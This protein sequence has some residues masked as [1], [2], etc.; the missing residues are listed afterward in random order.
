NHPM[1]DTQPPPKQT[2]RRQLLA[3]AARLPRLSGKASAAWLLICFILTGLLIPAVLRLP[4]WIEYEVVLAIW[5]VVWLAVLTRLLYTGQRVADDHRLQEPR[6]WF[7][8][9]KGRAESSPAAGAPSAV[10]PG[11]LASNKEGKQGEAVAKQPDTP[12][13]HRKGRDDHAAW[14]SGFFWGSTLGDGE[15]V[16]VGCLIVIGLVLLV[17]VIWFLVEIAITVVLFL[18]YF[19]VRGMLAQVINDRHHCR[20]RPGRA[21]ARGFVWATAYTAPLAAAVWFVHYVHHSPAAR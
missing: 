15:A 7:A 12:A 10:A 6:N 20:G 16:A 21:L 1:V 9:S 19:V 14:W 18:L 4:S 3:R 11:W 5:W 13:G 8:S 17:G 2:S